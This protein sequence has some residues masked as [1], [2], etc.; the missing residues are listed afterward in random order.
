MALTTCPQC[1]HSFDAKPN[2]AKDLGRFLLFNTFRGPFAQIQDFA[3]VKC[4]KCGTDYYDP[5]IRLFWIVTP[6][7]MQSMLLGACLAVLFLVFFQAYYY[8]YH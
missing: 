8:L 5:G 3:K 7:R 2:A 1:N 6:R 4:P